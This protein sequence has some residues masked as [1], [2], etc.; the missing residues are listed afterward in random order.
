MSEY[1]PLGARVCGWVSAALLAIYW[2]VEVAHSTVRN[3]SKQ[4]SHAV[5]TT[6]QNRQNQ[7][8]RFFDSSNDTKLHNE[9]STD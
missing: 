4:S 2:L 8:T 6:Q 1:K 9:L 7:N 5:L 3:V